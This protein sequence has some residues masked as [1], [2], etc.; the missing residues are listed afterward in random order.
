M[1]GFVGRKN[2]LSRLESIWCRDGRKAVVVYGRRKIGKTELLKRF[3]SDKRS[4]YIECVMGSVQDNIHVIHQATSILDS[5]ASSEPMFLKDALDRIL[6]CCMEQK[7]I[8]VFDELPYLLESGEHVGSSLQHFVDSLVRDTDSMIVICGSAMSVMSRETTDYTRPLYGRFTERMMIP[9][10]SFK[11][12]RGFHP[13]MSNM[14]LLKLYLTIG[15]IPQF[16]RDSGTDTYKEYVVRH[17]LSLDADMR[18]EGEALVTA[19]LAPAGRYMAV[20]NAISDGSTSLKEIADKTKIN[21]TT[22]IRCIE[23]LESIG[24]VGK[25][26]PMMGAPKRPI[27]RILDPTTAFCQS[28]VRESK[29]YMLRD[30]SMI[31]DELESRMSTHLGMRFED[32]CHGYALDRWNCLDCGKWWGAGPSKVIHEVDLVAIVKDG[33]SSYGLFGT[34]K[35]RNRQM[36]MSAY[37][38]LINDV[39]LI[40]TDLIRRYV[41]FSSSGFNDELREIAE[42]NGIFL[43]GPDE[44]SGARFDIQH[45]FWGMHRNVSG[46]CR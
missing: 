16:H 23:G 27:Y 3:C 29:A 9:P 40:D 10:L 18:D 19:E 35:F 25:V 15:G 30:P 14:D 32:F 11:E 20:I 31:Y 7:T 38:D 6:G 46:L 4:I 2:E 41:L 12:C 22:C 28:I 17:F 36:A 21:R 26:H 44:L 1:A 37:R 39:K 8:V 42:E 5:N 34:C 43:V 33:G 13:G 24:I 45:S